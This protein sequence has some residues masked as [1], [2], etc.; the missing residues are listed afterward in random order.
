MAQRHPAQ[1]A[2]HQRNSRQYAQNPKTGT[3]EVQQNLE[4]LEYQPI[5]SELHVQYLHHG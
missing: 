1:V 3:M 2:L 5:A 4:H